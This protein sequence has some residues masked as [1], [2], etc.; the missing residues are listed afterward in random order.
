MRTGA[1][2]VDELCQRDFS[3]RRVQDLSPEERRE[4]RRRFTEFMEA[5]RVDIPAAEPEPQK[6][7]TKWDP[8]LHGRKQ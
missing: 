1:I 7:V 2:P 4:L 3:D 5:L 6:P 8:A